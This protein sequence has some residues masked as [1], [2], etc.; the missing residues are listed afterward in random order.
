[1]ISL[2]A[3]PDACRRRTHISSEGGVMLL[4]M[5]ERRFGVAERLARCF[6]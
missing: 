6:P 5:A 2:R 1:M 3:T 4:A